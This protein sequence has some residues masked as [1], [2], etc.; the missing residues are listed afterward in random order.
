MIDNWLT[1]I[2]DIH[3]ANREDIHALKTE[4]ERVDRMCELNVIEQVKSVTHTTIVQEAWRRGQHLTVHGWIYGL[5]NGKVK[6]LGVAVNRVEQVATPY[7][8]VP[9]KA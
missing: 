3:A 9:S 1:K 7:R 2:R 6:D 5:K 4:E 8:V